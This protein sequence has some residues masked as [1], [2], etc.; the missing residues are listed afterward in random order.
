M[1]FGFPA[2]HSVTLPY[3]ISSEVIEATL[4]GKLNCRLLG[5]DGNK[6]IFKKYL[7]TTSTKEVL[8]TGNYFGEVITVTLEPNRTTIRCQCGLKTQCFDFGKNQR[9]V[10]MIVAALPPPLPNI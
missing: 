1:V 6:W 9:T 7:D 5:C 4:V 2:W 8:L 3:P 10:N